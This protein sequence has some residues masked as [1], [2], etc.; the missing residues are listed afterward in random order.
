MFIIDNFVFRIS[1]FQ[2]NIFLFENISKNE[3]FIIFFYYVYT[4]T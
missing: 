4:L 3:N 1:Y 2:K